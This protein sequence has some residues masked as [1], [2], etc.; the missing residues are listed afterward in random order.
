MFWEVAGQQFVF[1]N[2]NTKTAVEKDLTNKK[3]A[4]LLTF[5][6][7]TKNYWVTERVRLKFSKIAANG[8]TDD[9]QRA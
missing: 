1:L 4:K 9:W 2:Q 3:A 5:R 6:V 8:D 7:G